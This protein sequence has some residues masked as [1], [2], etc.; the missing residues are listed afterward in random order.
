MKD[1]DILRALGV[2]RIQ[3]NESLRNHSSWKIGGSADMLVQPSNIDELSHILQYVTENKLSHIVI[4]EGSN[5]LFDDRGFNGMVIK[6]SRAMSNCTITDD[7]VWAQAGIAVPRLARKIGLACLTGMEHAVGIPGTLGGLV[8]MNGGSQR[9][10]IGEIIK[11]V[12]CVDTLG[13]EIELKG[14]DC[15]FSYRDSIFLKKPWIITDVVLQLQ[16]GDRKEIFSRMLDILR[17]RRRKFPRRLPNC[18]SVFKSAPAL[19]AKCGPPG[20][21]IEE[22]GLKGFSI[23]D[24]QISPQHANFIV[25]TGHATAADVLALIGFIR[26]KVHKKTGVWLECEVRFVSSEGSIRPVHE[27]LPHDENIKIDR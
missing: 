22:L 11:S 9:K 3:V 4:G 19:Y 24:A 12:R 25:N 7:V 20:K 17:D 13:C 14:A 26:S 1:I 15:E 6:I 5:L 18:G 2:G 16:Q 21:V 27:I 8:A 10:G 23:G